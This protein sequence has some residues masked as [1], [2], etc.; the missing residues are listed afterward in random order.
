MTTNKELPEGC[1]PF[2]LEKAKAGHPCRTRSGKLARY[3]GEMPDTPV[4]NVVWDMSMGCPETTTEKGSFMSHGLK[5]A[6]DVFLTA[7]K[8]VK[9]TAWGNMF[10]GPSSDSS[11]RVSYLEGR[12]F[13]TEAEARQHAVGY[14]SRTTCKIEWEETAD[15]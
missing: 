6:E 4:C 5:N 10:N 9:R 7:P 1:L 11:F 15:E 14:D 3:I 2:D 8:M 12:V 13:K